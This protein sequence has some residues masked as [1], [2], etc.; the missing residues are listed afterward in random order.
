M[1]EMNENWNYMNEDIVREFKMLAYGI[2]EMEEIQEN[3]DSVYLQIP[4]YR[5]RDLNSGL[6]S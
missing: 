1:K 6:K 5:H 4:P 2:R 3:S